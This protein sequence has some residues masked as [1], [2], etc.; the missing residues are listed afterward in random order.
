GLVQDDFHENQQGLERVVCFAADSIQTPEPQLH[1]R[2]LALGHQRPSGFKRRLP[3]RPCCLLHPRLRAAGDDVHGAA[4]VRKPPVHVVDAGRDA[5]Q[6]DAER[7]HPTTLSCALRS[8]R[9]RMRSSS[10]MYS[11]SEIATQRSICSMASRTC[12]GVMVVR[13]GS[14]LYALAAGMPSPRTA[15]TASVSTP[16]GGR[17]VPR[18]VLITRV[19][20]ARPVS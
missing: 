9:S 12:S 5:G 18:H 14:W 16:G 3:R 19:T 11:S 13:G 17:R 4:S 8:I 20:A 2:L 15:S 6:H 10:A 7:H 1:V